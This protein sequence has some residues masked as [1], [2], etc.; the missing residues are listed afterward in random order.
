MDLFLAMLPKSLVYVSLL[1]TDTDGLTGAHLAA[2]YGHL[3]VLKRLLEYDPRQISIVN[4]KCGRVALHYAAMSILPQ[5]I[6]EIALLLD[7]LASLLL[8]FK[9]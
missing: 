8:Y 3:L 2:L 5:S 1:S 7:R 4:M 6:D 9:C